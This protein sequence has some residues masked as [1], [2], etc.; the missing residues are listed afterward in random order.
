MELKPV[1]FQEC[2]DPGD[3]TETFKAGGRVFLADHWVTDVTGATYRVP[4]GDMRAGKLRWADEDQTTHLADLMKEQGVEGTA[5][6]QVADWSVSPSGK[7]VW[8]IAGNFKMSTKKRFWSSGR[9]YLVDVETKAVTLLYEPIVR[10]D[11]ELR[12]VA[13]L[14]EDDVLLMSTRALRWFR[15]GKEVTRMRISQ[16]DRMVVGT[17]DRRRLALVKTRGPNGTSKTLL[18]EISDTKLTKLG[19]ILV[20]VHDVRFDSGQALVKLP[21]ETWHAVTV[22]PIPI[23][24]RKTATRAP[25]PLAK[26]KLELKRIAPPVPAVSKKVRERIDANPSRWGYARMFGPDIA[27][28]VHEKGR[29]EPGELVVLRHREEI[30][31]IEISSSAFRFEVTSDGKRAFAAI[32]VK[33][34]PG[35]RPADSIA[36]LECEIESTAKEWKALQVESGFF[37][38]DG[39]AC[40]DEDHLVVKSSTSLELLVRHGDVWKAV[41]R[42]K[43]PSGAT[44]CS[45]PQHDCVVVAGGKLTLYGRAGDKLQKLTEAK[46][47]SGYGNL[48]VTADGRLFAKGQFAKIK[49]R[50]K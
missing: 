29:D 47:F 31:R 16:G 44:L 25:H 37:G 21:D 50:K 42:V 27:A 6:N 32:R 8:C 15:V 39:L 43:C 40:F 20:A 49:P 28:G 34:P 22:P 18:I 5:W 13:A 19:E 4:V 41:H 38:A 17:V 14:G 12:Q 48:F 24:P 9:L 10:T 11:Y 30:A 2:R 3:P 46:L 36:V 26:A 1:G 45:Y 23:K 7:R 35:D 33:R